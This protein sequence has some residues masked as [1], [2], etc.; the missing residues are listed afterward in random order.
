MTRPSPPADS[1]RL[2]GLERDP[3]G[4]GWFAVERSWRPPFDV[5]ARVRRMDAQGA[6]GPALVELK[7]PGLTD[8][9]E[10]IA[11]E[12]RGDNVRLYILSDDNANPAQ[13]TLLLAFDVQ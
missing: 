8:N 10:G 11:A 12:T 6:L 7:L 9:F 3:R 1:W 13:K 5:R 2:T 4:G